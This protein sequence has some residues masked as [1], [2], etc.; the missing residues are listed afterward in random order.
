[1]GR[2]RQFYWVRINSKNTIWDALDGRCFFDEKQQKIQIEKQFCSKNNFFISSYITY[3]VVERYAEAVKHS[4]MYA[5][6][7]TSLYSYSWKHN[8]TK[9]PHI[10]LI[11]VHHPHLGDFILARG[12]KG[13]GDSFIEVIFGELP[14]RPIYKNPS[15]L[16]FVAVISFSDF[17]P[18][19]YVHQFMR[20]AEIGKTRRRKW[21]FETW[22]WAVSGCSS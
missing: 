14:S 19:F 5:H 8:E 2:R 9:T 3:P 7:Y 13:G 20:K 16:P 11:Y 18:S 22:M 6:I 1:M 21:C 12:K 15:F 10:F 4:H 17:L